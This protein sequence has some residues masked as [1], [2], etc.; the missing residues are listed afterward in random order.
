MLPLSSLMLKSQRCW[1]LPSSVVTALHN[2]YAAFCFV[3]RPALTTINMFFH[4]QTGQ[5]NY[6]IM[7]PTKQARDLCASGCAYQQ[8]E[9]G[10]DITG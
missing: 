4:L 7:F 1:S 6:L 3:V 8:V 10:R 2:V 9:P 5:S